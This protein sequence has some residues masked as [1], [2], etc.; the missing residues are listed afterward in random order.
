M[1]VSDVETS[2]KQEKIMKQLQRDI[3]M[4]YCG[5][6]LMKIINFPKALL[7]RFTNC[8]RQTPPTPKKNNFPARDGNASINACPATWLLFGIRLMG[9]IEFYFYCIMILLPY[10]VGDKTKSRTAMFYQ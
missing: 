4:N 5:L 8:F 9:T 6:K 7:F 3:S 2:S 10:N 1:Y